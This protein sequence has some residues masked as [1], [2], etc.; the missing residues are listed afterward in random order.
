MKH[1][2]FN[3]FPQCQNYIF[4]KTVQHYSMIHGVFIDIYKQLKKDQQNM[5]M[6]QLFD[7]HSYVK[8]KKLTQIIQNALIQ[9]YL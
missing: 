2:Q 9:G 4:C 6:F 3:N 1:L 8:K 5:I 7:K